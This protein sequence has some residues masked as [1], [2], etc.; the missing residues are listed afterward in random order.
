[1]TIV[2]HQDDDL[3]FMNPDIQEGISAGRDVTVVYVTAGD[4]GEPQSYWGERETGVKAA[5]A[6]MAGVSDWVD[7]VVRF[8]HDGTD[9]QVHSSTLQSAPQIRLYF[10][11]LPDGGELGFSRYGFESLAQLNDGRITEISTVDGAATYTRA[12]VVRL[13][14]GLLERHQPDQIRVQDHESQFADGEHRDH[15]HTAIY[16]EEAIAGYSAS[17]YTVTSYVH[18]A[19]SDL[20][21]NLDAQTADQTLQTFEDYAEF[22]PYVFE[23]EGVLNPL[24]SAWVL[25]Q[26][27]AEETTVAPA[28]TT[29]VTGRYFAEGRNEGIEGTGDVGVSGA[30]VY[31]YDDSM[32]TI[33][34]TARTDLTGRYAF[35]D[36]PVDAGY[37]VL[38]QD[39]GTLGGP[40]VSYG[41]SR[42]GQGSDET[43]DSD[44]TMLLAG[45]AGATE[46]F[47][48]AAGQS[49][50]D[51]D[52][53]IFNAQ[54][55]SISG[56]YFVDGNGD[57]L[58]AMSDAGVAGAQVTLFDPVAQTIVG[59]TTTGADGL[60]TFSNVVPGQTYEVRFE[61]PSDLAG[62][63]NYFFTPGD[64]G[65]DD[66]LDSDVT[67]ELPD[68]T[69]QASIPAFPVGASITNLDAG[70]QNP[71]AAS[72]SGRYFV[73]T[74]G[75]GLE[76][77][78]EG[79]VSGAT[80]TLY[81]PATYAVAATAQTDAD[82]N[83]RFDDVA[84]APAYQVR[85]DYG[86]ALPPGFDAH[87]FTTGNA[88]SDDAIDS[89]VIRL[90]YTGR[91]ETAAF[92]VAATQSLTNVDAGLR[93]PSPA[94]V[95]GRYFIDHDDNGLDDGG[96]G[97]ADATVILMQGEDEVAV[98]TTSA[99]GSYRFD[100]VPHG[101]DYFVIFESAAFVA[102]VEI[103][104]FA[105]TGTGDGFFGGL[106]SRVAEEL[107][108]GSGA[109]GR[110]DLSPGQTM[111]GIN[112]GVADFLAPWSDDGLLI[113]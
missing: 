30:T 64:T 88:G 14:E 75:N 58:R 61:A 101:T 33:I 59:S 96:L 89:D 78:G 67:G 28:G 26:Y 69:G 38:F 40:Y 108:F 85:F 74:N 8:R 56:R 111:S 49:R 24:Y 72:I 1:M 20:R 104:G 36:V 53:A 73:D 43:R 94:S 98:T 82:G 48:I 83:Y 3:L 110:F 65:L 22:D 2:A 86:A 41:F 97:L 107:P 21:A 60:Y 63:E 13:L 102:E 16:T 92:S 70:I 66:R 79:G 9:Y 5:Y 31:L 57:G 4:A 100:D 39:P 32:A 47:A 103:N 81:N 112:A 7:E 84:P 106:V 15:V 35:H 77:V 68:G 18:Y 99:N 62:F 37:R 45:G 44:V 113:G 50:S 54:P 19:T 93:P 52:A 12:E 11:R 87:R 29:S 95:T 42:A 27:V 105:G 25:R 34:A 90:T 46:L 76:D 51:I 10:L 71:M 23:S 109:T 55:S 17:Q 80:V 91:G 6:T